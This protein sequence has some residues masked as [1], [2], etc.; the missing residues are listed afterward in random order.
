MENLKKKCSFKKHSEI[1]AIN[2]CL[3]CKIYLCNKCQSLHSELFDNHH[4]Y[5]LDINIKDIFTGFCMENNHN[6]ELE[7]FC[8]SHNKLC[9]A[10]CIV[11]RKG[12]GKGQHTD[13]EIL[14][15]N[16]IKQEKK[17]KLKNNIESLE[18]LFNKW[19]ESINELKKLFS[20][21]NENKE[22]LKIELQKIFTKIR[23]ALNEREDEL[24]LQVEKK[25][26]KLYFN[27]EIIKESEKLPNKIKKSL[28]TGKTA[29]KEWNDDNKLK[30]FINECIN[31]E[32]NI[33]E[34]NKINEKIKNCNLNQNIKINFIPEEN[35]INKFIQTIKTFGN[36]LDN[37]KVLL[38]NS[39]IINSGND[40]LKL[41][42]W[43]IDSI[44]NIKSFEL[45]Y[46]ATEHG[47]TNN[48]SFNKCKNIPNLIWIMKDKNNNIF[49]CF[50]SIAI[51][52][53]GSK[54]KDLK[55][56]LYSINNNKKYLPNLNIEY[57][58]N[59]WSSHLVEL[60]CS[61]WEFAVA[62]KFLS[63]TS[64]TFKKGN[65]FNHNLELCNNKTSISLSE[66]EVYK[67]IQ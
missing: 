24:L 33:N 42:K 55:C 62:D 8:K 23:T 44:G 50:T 49:G 45:I 6:N 40:I 51:T 46:R 37:H 58:L 2:Y 29:D 7:Y 60:G 66:L 41:E 57:N 11:K 63:S 4:I 47:N 48:V 19:D 14:F 16:E 10:S 3:E 26:D 56:F 52:S 22:K 36:L 65:V 32:N 31:I 17:N 61:V 15:L 67:V 35:E 12:E 18:I 9:C 27:E 59:H 39:K 53:S 30:Y 1:E 20:T 54:S 34:I 38:N 25:Y 43:L 5:N 28:E 13:C 64:V 21:I